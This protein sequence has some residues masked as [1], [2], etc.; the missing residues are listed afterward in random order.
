LKSTQ[1]LELAEADIKVF[2]SVYSKEQ[3][4]E[5]S[6]RGFVMMRAFCEGILKEKVSFSR[7]TSVLDF[8]NSYL[9]IGSPSV[10]LDIG[11]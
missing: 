2:G 3:R 8:F 1:G 10:L 11:D 5:T 4:T 7:Q 6:R 9:G